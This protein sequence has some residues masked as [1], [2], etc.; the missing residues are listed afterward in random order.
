MSRTILNMSFFLFIIL[1]NGVIQTEASPSADIGQ[2]FNKMGD[3]LSQTAATI[4]DYLLELFYRFR[5]FFIGH[6]E[7][8][9]QSM[10]SRGCGYAQDDQPAIYNKHATVVSK[11]K[12]GN[13]AIW[14]TWPWM[15]SLFTSPRQGWSC[16]GVLINENTVL[17][18]AHCL[19]HTSA[20][21]MKAII[22]VHTIL[23]KLNPLNYYSISA[24]HRHPK[25]ENC[26]KNDLAILKLSKPVLYGPKINSVC[27]PFQPY[28]NIS[29]GRELVNRT[30]IIIGWGDSSQNTITN[31][32]KSFT[33]Q[34]ADVRIFDDYYCRRSYGHVFDPNT[35]ICAGDYEQ[36]RDTMSGDSGGPLLIRQSDGRWTVLGITSYGSATS[37]SLAPG[38][39]VKLSAHAQWLEPFIKSN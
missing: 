31:M 38:V 7:S 11:I 13:D 4:K 1:L 15:V 23:G 12:G 27:L 22:G 2:F 5:A 26:C 24:I 8:T 29:Q 28:A 34:Q 36:L 35:E 3:K 10:T 21:E 19:T 25:F 17:T 39:Y 6:S 33:L 18:A 32:V 14:H 9:H 37:P 30:G 16:A 20:G